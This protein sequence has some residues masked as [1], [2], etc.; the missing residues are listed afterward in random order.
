[1]LQ[2]RIWWVFLLVLAVGIAV[3]VRIVTLGDSVQAVNR[4]FIAEK[5]PLS[6]R[7]G[8]LRGVIADEERMLYEYYSYTATRDAFQTQRA[9]NRARLDSIVGQL[10]KDTDSHEQVSELRTRLAALDE[11][12]DE[13]SNTLSSKVVNWDLARAILAQVKP[14]VRQIESTL[15][16]MSATNQQA[17]DMLGNDSRNSVSKMVR[18]VIGFSVLI[19]SVAFF[20]GYYVVAI[21]REG[22]ERR[23]LAMFAERNPNPVLRLS[24]T[25]EVRYANPATAELLARL[26]IPTTDSGKLLPEEMQHHLDEAHLDQASNRQFE[27]SHGKFTLECTVAFLA[28]FSEFQVYIKDVT[29]RRQAEEKLAYQ[30][31]FDPATGLPNQYRLREDLGNSFAQQRAGTVMMIVADREQEIFE[32]LGAVETERWLVKVALRLRDG[33]NQNERKRGDALP[34]RR[35]CVRVGLLA[36]GSGGRAT[37]SHTIARYRKAAAACRTARAVFNA[38]DRGRAD[39]MRCRQRSGEPG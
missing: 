21:I 3:S 31:F 36:R 34:F 17:V 39:G 38:V 20:V 32:S 11:L 28:D 15:A 1:M 12:S 29:A 37:A 16:A 10:D 35:E 18:W 8:E 9:L 25:G 4:M 24:A 26:N 33:I 5:L 13:L 19:F 6:Q 30:A 7:I 14:K 27:Y 2:R 22:M 23:R